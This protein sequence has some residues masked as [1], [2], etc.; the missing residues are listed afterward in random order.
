MLELVFPTTNRIST[1]AVWSK[2][3]SDGIEA[4]TSARNIGI[5]SAMTAYWIKKSI[6]KGVDRITDASQ[7]GLPQQ[8]AILQ[9]AIKYNSKGSWQWVLDAAGLSCSNPEFGSNCVASLLS[10]E[11]AGKPGFHFFGV[12]HDDRGGHAMGAYIGSDSF[13]FFDANHGLF[14]GTRRIDFIVHV[15]HQL[16][17][18]YGEILDNWCRCQVV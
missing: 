5:C 2:T 7:L 11:M 1:R 15:G 6:E 3:A 4:L 13:Y 14:R 12:S 8:I 18:R 9:G 16:D 10:T 17:S